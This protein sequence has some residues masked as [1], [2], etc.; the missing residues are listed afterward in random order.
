MMWREGCEIT[1]IRCGALDH[2]RHALVKKSGIKVLF[3]EPQYPAKAAETIARETGAK[4]FVLDPA[5]TGPEVPD[6]Y[7]QTM[8]GNLKILEQAF[9]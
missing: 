2:K 1:S 8:E 6:A 5:V 9:K 4:I 3:S 7:L